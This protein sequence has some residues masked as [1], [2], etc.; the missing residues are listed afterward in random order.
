MKS[1][2]TDRTPLTTR[3]DFLRTS[4][5]ALA[6][7]A[8]AAPLAVPR[9]GYAAE[10]NTIKI[11]LVGC[12]GRGT[13]AAANALSTKGPTKLVALADVFPERIEKTHKILS[14]KFAAQVDVPPER[15]FV[16]FDAFRKAID[17]LGKGDLVLL[18]TPAA[19]RP[20]HLEYAV[21]KG[22]NVFMEK[23]FAVDAPGIRRVLRAGEEAQQKNLKVAS[24]LMWRHDP[25]REEVIRR[26]HDGAIGDIILLRTYRMHG[27]VGF[28]PRQPGE[29]ELAHQLR[30]YSCFNWLNASF[31]VDWLIHNIDVCCWAKNAW[32]VNVQGQGARV[33]RTDPDQMLDQYSVEYT[34]ADGTKLF[35]QGRHVTGCWDIFSDFAQGAKG[36]ALLMESLAAAKPRIFKGHAQ[37]SESLVW[38]YQGPAVD[39]Y[40]REH[41]LLFDAIRNDKPCNETERAAKA[42]LVS[43]MGRMAAESGLVINYDEALASNLELAP[44]LDKIDSLDALA[45]VA[46]DAAGKY[47]V[48]VP[49]RTKVL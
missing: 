6:G 8:L 38:R 47:P 37:T 30:N 13:G 4:S 43:I 1:S 19:F 48:Q 7:A 20:I 10:D 35:A 31:F 34:F 33:A 15:R 28:H 26:L 14:E 11:A 29:S 49:G 25:P 21:Q 16:G 45:P 32:P 39:P 18:A 27:P 42:C 24:G 5:T 9:P 40:Q 41:D 17:G 2:P 3:R 23:S 22:V 12:G 44:G 46:P 36:S